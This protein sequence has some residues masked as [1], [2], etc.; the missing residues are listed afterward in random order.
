MV[1]VAFIV[2][3]KV[4][5]IFIDF[6]E[7]KGWFSQKNIHKVGPTIDAKGGGNLC[8]HN[9][10]EFVDQAQTCN[11]D[12]IFILTDL[13]CDPCIEKT[14][15]RLGNCD[16]C[17]I[18][19][20]RKALEAWFLADDFLLRALTKNALTHYQMPETTSEMPYETFKGLL[21]E[22]TGRGTGSKVMFA[23]KVC[24]Q[25]FDIEMASQHEN[26]QSAKYFLDK[27]NSVGQNQ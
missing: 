23:K 27:I 4:E 17:V 7:E 21:V 5:K 18:V 8:P 14:K 15:E 25:G 2:E 19:I 11:P 13:E 6:L 10:Q 20:A 24:K 12:K 22:H 16:S 3:G 26:C 9:I 1:K